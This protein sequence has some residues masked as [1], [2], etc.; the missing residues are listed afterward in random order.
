MT[1]ACFL[2]DSATKSY[3]Y[4][5]LKA[6]CR[7]HIGMHLR[8]LLII[9]RTFFC[10]HS[11]FY[12][13]HTASTVNVKKCILDKLLTPPRPGSIKIIWHDWTTQTNLQTW[14]TLNLSVGSS[15][16]TSILAR[17]SRC[18]DQLTREPTEM[19]LHSKINWKDSLSLSRSWQLLIHSP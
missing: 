1:S 19:K 18:M 15:L 12:T 9:Q 5:I 10:M 8:K 14:K 17:K 3:T 6:T 11:N 4:R 13:I 2:R 7:L 16:K